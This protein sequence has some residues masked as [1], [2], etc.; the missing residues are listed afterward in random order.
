MKLANEMSFN[1]VLYV[2]IAVFGFLTSTFGGDE[3]KQ[4]LSPLTLFWCKT[5]TGCM[6]AGAL[7]I[8]LFLSTSYADWQSKKNGN[9]NGN[10]QTTPKV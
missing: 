10:G 6:S 3:A 9:G 7:A 2:A 4:F 8:K 5:I 1:L